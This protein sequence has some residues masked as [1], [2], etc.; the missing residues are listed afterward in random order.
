MEKLA[1]KQS[2]VVCGTMIRW[3][4]S[5]TQLRDVVKKDSDTIRAPLELIRPSWF[6]VEIDTRCQSLEEP[7]EDEDEFAAD[8]PRDPMNV[9]LLK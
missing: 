3:C 8:V 2:L 7:D 5:A 4:H 9:T 1:L 6:S